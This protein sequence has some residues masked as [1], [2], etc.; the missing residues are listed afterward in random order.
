MNLVCI[1]PVQIGY[2]A[3]VYFLG[4]AFGGLAFT[5]PDQIGR[6]KSSLYGYVLALVGITAMIA[7]PD[8]YVRMASFFV[9]GVAT[10]KDI[11]SPI[12]AAELVGVR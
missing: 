12:W 1:T 11:A 10:I 7:I 9:L 8:Y 6:K 3:S 5:L 4:Y 2:M